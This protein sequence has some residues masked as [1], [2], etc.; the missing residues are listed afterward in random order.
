MRRDGLGI[1]QF[2]LI[3]VVHSH[4]DNCAQVAAERLIKYQK[5]SDLSGCSFSAN[6][7]KILEKSSYVNEL[8][9]SM[10]HESY[11]GILGNT[12]LALASIDRGLIDK[13]PTLDYALWLAGDIMEGTYMVV[14]LDHEAPPLICDEL[15]LEQE[16]H[17]P[18]VQKLAF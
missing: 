14:D 13:V 1:D 6:G 18:S 16:E 8:V 4:R 17:F 15:I 9:L 12:A 7:H 10:M 5:T 2:E 11:I 3:T